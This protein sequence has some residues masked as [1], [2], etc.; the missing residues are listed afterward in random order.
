MATRVM[1]GFDPADPQDRK[2]IEELLVYFD[3]RTMGTNPSLVE[4]MRRTKVGR[5]FVIPVA[6]QIVPDQEYTV[7]QLRKL[8]TPNISCTKVR[9]LIAVLGTPERRLGGSIFQKRDGEDGKLFS[10]SAEMKVALTTD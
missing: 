5:T 6:R 3:Q 9:S 8:V 4:A 1:F 10:M 7:K 2:K